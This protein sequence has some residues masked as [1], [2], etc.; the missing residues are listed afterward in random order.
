MHGSRTLSV[1][2][3]VLGTW[4][5]T[6]GKQPAF[7]MGFTLFPAGLSPQLSPNMGEGIIGC[8]LLALS[9]CTLAAL[10]DLC[11]VLA[12]GLLAVLDTLGIEYATHDV[13]THT[14]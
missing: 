3:Y 7:Y 4:Y 2:I 14:R 11:A 12:A 9:W 6:T 13:V 1:P 5:V 8:L 10:S